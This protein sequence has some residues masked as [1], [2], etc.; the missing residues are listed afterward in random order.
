[1]TP[2]TF[3]SCF[4]FGFILGYIVKAFVVMINS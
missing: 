3:F 1:M 4:F 2:E